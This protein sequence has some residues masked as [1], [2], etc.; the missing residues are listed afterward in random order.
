MKL[1]PFYFIGPAFY[2]QTATVTANE[3]GAKNKG[4]VE[5]IIWRLKFVV[6][7]P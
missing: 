3:D 5:I 2:T 4:K 1:F 6:T 7:D